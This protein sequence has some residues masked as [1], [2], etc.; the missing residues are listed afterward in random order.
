VN[1]QQVEPLAQAQR[2]ARLAMTQQGLQTEWQ[3]WRPLV[4]QVQAV[5][6][7]EP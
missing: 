5:W 7:W 4:A 3:A 6:L 2:V 1:R